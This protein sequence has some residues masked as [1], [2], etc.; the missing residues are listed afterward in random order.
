MEYYSEE[1]NGTGKWIS[2]SAIAGALGKWMQHNDLFMRTIL[3]SNTGQWYISTSDCPTMM[4]AVSE[5]DILDLAGMYH[6][7]IDTCRS[8]PCDTLMLV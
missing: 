6:M 2:E 4:F 1:P 8:L 5:E 7:A 3:M